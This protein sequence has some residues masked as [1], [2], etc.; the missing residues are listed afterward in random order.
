ML[1]QTSPVTVQSV[2]ALQSTSPSLA[3]SQ[4]FCAVGTRLVSTQAWP[5]AESH[6]ESLVQ[7]CGH[8]CA[9]WHTLPAAP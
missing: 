4:L 1:Q 5:L 9:D 6:V 2:S 7:N 3:G 8:V